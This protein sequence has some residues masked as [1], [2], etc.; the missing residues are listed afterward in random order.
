MGVA[1]DDSIVIVKIKHCNACDLSSSDSESKSE[2]DDVTQLTWMP[3]R[4]QC[5]YVCVIARGHMRRDVSPFIK[6]GEKV[7]HTMCTYHR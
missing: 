7:T 3:I 2:L 6:Q 5:W 1:H 4:F